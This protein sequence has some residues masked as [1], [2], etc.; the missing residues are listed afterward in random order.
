MKRNKTMRILA[1]LLTAML[2]LSIGMSAMAGSVKVDTDI[3]MVDVAELKSEWKKDQDFTLADPAPWNLSELKQVV[4]VEDPRSVAAYFVWSVTRLVDDY[5]DGMEM[6]KYLFADLEPYGSGFTEGGMSGK[7][8]W[9][10]YFNERLKSSD[11]KW[12]PRAYFEGAEGDNGFTPERPLTLELYY[13]DTNTMTLN[14]QSYE[15]LGRLD[16]TYWIKSHAAGNQVNIN[17][18][19][20]DGSDRW[21][22]TSGTTSTAM[23]YDQRGGL[24]ASAKTALKTAVNDASTEA[25]HKAR[26]G[27]GD[28]EP[29]PEPLPFTDVDPSDNFADAI[30]W[31]YGN[32]VTTG[33][34]A[35]TFGPMDSCTRGQVVTF[36]WRAAGE[37]APKNS[38]NPFTDVRSSDYY[39]KPILWAVENGITAG[40]SATTFSPDQTCSS[41]HIITFLYRANG[42]GSDG[43][44]EVAKNWATAEG[45][46]RATGITVS[47]EETCPRGAVVTFLYRTYQ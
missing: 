21:Y 30:A 31:A 13:N 17:V 29:E 6:M 24:S 36:L 22:V 3:E 11:Y 33:T 12:L 28:A 16:I 7:A 34:S 18:M 8:G 44:Y 2:V 10:T 25:E 27:G 14:A 1:A 23:F 15:Q 19:K 39:Y 38:N 40:T 35:T 45:L 47:P 9:D 32:K 5:N 42:I 41:A 46:L 4:D 20:F 26:Y 43:W 37:P